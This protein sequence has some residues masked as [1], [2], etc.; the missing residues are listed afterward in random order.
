MYFLLCHNFAFQI[1][2]QFLQIG[3]S[4]MLVP[5]GRWRVTLSVCIMQI[6]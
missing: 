2:N 5:I 4:I 6:T 1:K 3:T